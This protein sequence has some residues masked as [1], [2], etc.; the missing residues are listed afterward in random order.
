MYVWETQKTLGAS[1]IRS[2]DGG[3]LANGKARQLED[4]FGRVGNPADP[5]S[6]L[7]EG[8]VYVPYDG[9][10]LSRRHE[11]NWFLRLSPEQIK[12]SDLVWARLAG[13]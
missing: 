11:F 7:L 3:S 9:D 12:E 5:K 10:D 4:L 6:A 8:T 13:F 1:V 2:A